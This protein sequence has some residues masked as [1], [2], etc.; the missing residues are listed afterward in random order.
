[1][2]FKLV[3]INLRKRVLY[4]IEAIKKRR[5]RQLVV[6]LTG[7]FTLHLEL[8]AVPNAKVEILGLALRSDML[9][10]VR[11]PDLFVFPTLGEGFG[12]V[13]VE[14]LASGTPVIATTAC[15]EVVREGVEGHMVAARSGRD[16]T[17]ARQLTANPQAL[18]PMREAAVGGAQEFSLEGYARRLLASLA[19]NRC[20]EGEHR[21][22][23]VIER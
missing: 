16:R 11:W 6:Q 17:L 3:R 10:L 15:G 14:A 18:A 12:L 7:S 5:T 13:Q 23:L 20:R 4:L 1:M 22:A 19:P 9:A 8:L 2:Y 21:T